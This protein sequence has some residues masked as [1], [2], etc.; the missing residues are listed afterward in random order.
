MEL[1]ASNSDDQISI[2]SVL[3]VEPWLVELKEMSLIAAAS[4]VSVLSVEPW[5]VEP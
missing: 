1:L 4:G 2:V 3:S 5:L